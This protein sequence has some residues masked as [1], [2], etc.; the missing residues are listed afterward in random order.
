V[1]GLSELRRQ[2]GLPGSDPLPVNFLKHADEQTVAALTAVFEAVRVHGLAP[3]N[4]PAPFHDWGAIAAP[5]FLGRPLMTLALPRFQQE[6]AWGVSPHLIPHRSLHSISGTVSQ[7]LKI[8][9]PNFGV[10]GGP[11]S[12]AEALLAGISL[13][14][15]MKLP[16]VWI[17]FS[18]LEPESACDPA[19][20][21]PVP[22]T[23][24]HGLALAL[25]PPGSSPG[26]PTLELTFQPG[27]SSAPPLTLAVLEGLLAGLSGRAEPELAVPLG[28]VGRLVL[29]RPV[30]SILSG[31]HSSFHVPVGAAAS[32]LQRSEKS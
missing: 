19:T 23:V 29:R 26:R 8:H 32:S 15:D 2:G 21:R 30:R 10:G 16:G 18:R 22:G 14:D 31:P 6:G 20:G 28:G 7:A 3:A 17:V 1:E 27:R 5:R 11:G 4:R 9:G 24:A 12:E 13:L 25:T